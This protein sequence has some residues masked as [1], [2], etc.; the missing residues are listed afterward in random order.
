MCKQCRLVSLGAVCCD[1]TKNKTHSRTPN[2][3]IFSEF[4]AMA[5]PGFFVALEG[6][7][8]RL[9]EE[10]NAINRKSFLRVA[11]DKKPSP[12][13]MLKRSE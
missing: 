3:M 7:Y 9:Y 5:D 13:T 10:L 11:H 12:P 2:P 6:A 8:D 1:N 4:R